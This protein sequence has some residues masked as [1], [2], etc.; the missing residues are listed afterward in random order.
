MAHENPAVFRFDRAR[1]TEF[2]EREDLRGIFRPH[3]GRGRLPHQSLIE[4]V[5]LALGQIHHVGVD[6]RAIRISA[7][8]VER[9]N[10]LAADGAYGGN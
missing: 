5:P 8:G 4:D 10:L 7:A 2:E 1:L 9:Q 3:H 6:A